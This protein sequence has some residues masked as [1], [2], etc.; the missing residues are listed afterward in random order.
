MLDV[1]SRRRVVLR[2]DEFSGEKM[3]SDPSIAAFAARVLH[4]LCF[5][6]SVTRSLHTAGHRSQCGIKVT[7]LLAL[8]ALEGKV[9]SYYLRQLAQETA[10][11]VPGFLQVCNNLDLDQQR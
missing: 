10:L 6:D 11:A 2:T 8:S 4:N 7:V 9:S 5:A 3:D 1:P